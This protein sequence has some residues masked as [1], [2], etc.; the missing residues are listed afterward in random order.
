MVKVSV[1]IGLQCR[2]DNTVTQ[3]PHFVPHDEEK[4]ASRIPIMRPLSN[5]V[6][7][8]FIIK[9][10]FHGDVTAGSVVQTK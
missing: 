7:R 4:L 6:N 10:C 8:E 9:S 3:C 5:C 2:H 1:N